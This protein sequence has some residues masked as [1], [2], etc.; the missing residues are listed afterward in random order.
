MIPCQAL[1]VLVFYDLS[2]H[3]PTNS[4]YPPSCP[5]N[6]WLEQTLFFPTPYCSKIARF[7]MSMIWNRQATGLAPPTSTFHPLPAS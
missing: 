3:L 5:P 2:A 7:M 6:S 4:L 1:E